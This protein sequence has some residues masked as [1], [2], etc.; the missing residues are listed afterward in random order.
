V[1][2]SSASA[3][4]ASV[5]YVITD[6]A[7]RAL[8]H[9]YAPSAATDAAPGR[10][11]QLTH[12]EASAAA[13]GVAPTVT[14]NGGNNP[15]AGAAA[16][17]SGA[18]LPVAADGAGQSYRHWVS[19]PPPRDRVLPFSRASPAAESYI[20]AYEAAARETERLAG[21][22]GLFGRAVYRQ[23]LPP[24]PSAFAVAGGSAGAAADRLVARL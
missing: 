23:A 14:Q 5:S 13:S 18:A 15:S 1:T 2:D 6:P 7:A 17:A 20:S 3:G 9:P 21:P 19:P 10:I 22:A 8:S 4:A 12:A 11:A 16:T 24:P